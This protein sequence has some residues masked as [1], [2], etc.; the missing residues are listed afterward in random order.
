MNKEETT[1]EQMS[2]QQ[3]EKEISD[4]KNQIQKITDS[5]NLDF[6]EESIQKVAKES[7]ELESM[8][9]STKKMLLRVIENSIKTVE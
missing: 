7:K 9:T 2:Y 1:T 4:L 3:M 5:Y 6:V 8:S